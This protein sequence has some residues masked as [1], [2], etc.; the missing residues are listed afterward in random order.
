MFEYNIC[1]QADEE[2]FLK[3]CIALEKNIPQLIKKDILEDVDG[4]KTQ[5]YLKNGSNITVH[6]SNYIGA[7]YIQSD[8]SLEKFFN[9]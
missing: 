7:V 6:N 9:K 8:I 5:A 4:S 1:T 2:V 3:Q